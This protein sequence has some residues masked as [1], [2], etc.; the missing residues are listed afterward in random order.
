MTYKWDFPNRGVGDRERL[1]HLIRYAFEQIA[2]RHPEIVQRR[3]GVSGGELVA[4]IKRYGTQLPGVA[5]DDV[6][7]VRLESVRQELL[8]MEDVKVLDAIR[9]NE[10][11]ALRAWLR[12]SA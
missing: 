6:A 11:F 10:R 8:E 2:Q 7:K 5:R 4:A 3:L 9:A 12:R 1:R